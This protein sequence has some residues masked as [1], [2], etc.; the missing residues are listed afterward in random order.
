M[1]NR[2]LDLED[3]GG[4]R[5][6]AGKKQDMLINYAVGRTVRVPHRRKRIELKYGTLKARMDW[7][8]DKDCL[9]LRRRIGRLNPGW[10]VEGYAVKQVLIRVRS[11]V[12]VRVRDRMPQSR[13][14]TIGA[15]LIVQ[16]GRTGI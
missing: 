2:T 11:N 1:R 12:L 7:F 5:L 15:H 16:A 10:Q 9:Q 13:E 8:N 3:G 4:E 14:R 6:T